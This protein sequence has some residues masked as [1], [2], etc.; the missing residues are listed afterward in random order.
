MLEEENVILFFMYKIFMIN[1]KY[2]F[3]CKRMGF[4]Y[5]S[6]I[7]VLFIKIE[8]LYLNIYKEIIWNFI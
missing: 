5:F 3:Y 1:F 6:I 4:S 2:F 8:N 7:I